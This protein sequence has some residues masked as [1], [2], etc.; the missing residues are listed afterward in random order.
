MEYPEVVSA[1][2]QLFGFIVEKTAK[3]MKLSFSRVLADNEADITVDQW[4]IMNILHDENA[5]SQYQIAQRSYKDA[6]T[7]T[8]ILDLLEQKGYIRRKPA[9]TDRRKFEIHLT[10]NGLKKVKT[11]LPLAQSFR[12]RCYAGL[13]INDLQQMEK[14][15]NT[16]FENLNL[17]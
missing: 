14:T 15:M 2:E 7:V 4:V 5:I 10:E 12:Q 1:R 6:P 11:I 17:S 9:K 3:K 16:I 13:D 8:R